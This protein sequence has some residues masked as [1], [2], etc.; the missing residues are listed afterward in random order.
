VI[1][2]KERRERRERDKNK[3]K[4]QR[5]RQR[6]KKYVS[7]P[8]NTLNNAGESWFTPHFDSFIETL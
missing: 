6:T 7:G 5:L 1:G 3:K 8:N 4:K 2:E